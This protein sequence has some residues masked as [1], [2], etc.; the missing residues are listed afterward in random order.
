MRK[1]LVDVVC[2]GDWFWGSNKMA[3]TLAIIATLMLTSAAQAQSLSDVAA[4]RAE[5]VFEQAVADYK[6][7]LADH[8][9]NSLQRQPDFMRDFNLKPQAAPDV[10]PCEAERH[11]M[12]ASAQAAS[13]HNG[14]R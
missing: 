8:A 7:C 13:R 14:S 12:D 10:N 11:I 9:G 3:R 2:C 1:V 4:I 6:Q 5:R